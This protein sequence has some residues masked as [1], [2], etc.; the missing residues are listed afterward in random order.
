MKTYVLMVSL[1]FPKTHKKAG[2]KTYFKEKIINGL[3]QLTGEK[4][5][6]HTIRLNFNFWEKRAKEINEGKA[7]LS[8]RYWSGKPYKSKQV[9]IV[10][11]EKIGIEKLVNPDNFVY[12]QIGHRIT[13]W[14][15]IAQNDG[16]SFNDFCEWFKTK[17]SE[18]MAII[19]FTDFRYSA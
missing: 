16:L 2:E 19:H 17:N 14:N 9:E 3:A 1:N 10:Q 4:C 18:P 8:I 5:K 11:L 15:F 6:I 13:N 12:A 7:I